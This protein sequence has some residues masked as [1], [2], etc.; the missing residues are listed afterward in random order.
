MDNQNNE[1]YSDFFKV[2]LVGDAGVG[3]THLMT[4]YVKGCLP[5]NAVPT[6]GI[7]F[8]GKTVTLQNGKKVKAQIWDTAGQERYRGITSTHFRKAGGALV[9]YD[10]TKEKTFESVVK[11]MEDLRYQAEPDVVIMLVG[12]KID[13]VENNGSA[14]LKV[15]KEDAKNLAQQHKVL[16]EESS[17]VTGQNVGQCFDRLLQEM[18]K[19]KSLTPGQDNQNQGISLINQNQT[20]N[21]D[22]CKC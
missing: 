19:I 16:F 14:R 11:W 22:N 20:Q 15:Q 1:D 10:V 13:L 5:K 3:K 12:N 9:V 17:A 18:Y 4:R 6:I 8:A 2:V 7:E 21:P